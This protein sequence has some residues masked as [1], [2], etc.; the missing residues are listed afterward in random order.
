MMAWF[1][2]RALG[3]EPFGY[4]GGIKAI[5][6]RLSVAIPPETGRK[7]NASQRDASLRSMLHLALALVA[8]IPSGR[9]SLAVYSGGVAGAQPPNGFDASG[10]AWGALA[11]LA[12]LRSEY[13]KSLKYSDTLTVNFADFGAIAAV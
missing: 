12:G 11:G 8:G 7:Y 3:A 2:K 4:A 5:S 10:I 13:L 9:C 1:L 6:R